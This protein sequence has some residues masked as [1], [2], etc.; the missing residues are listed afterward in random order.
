MKQQSSIPLLVKQFGVFSVVLLFMMTLVSQVFAEG[1]WVGNW[2]VLADEDSLT[3]CPTDLAVDSN[4]TVYV[5]DCGFALVL[6]R[7]KEATGWTFLPNQPY[8]GSN[9]YLAGLAVD[10]ANNVYVLNGYSGTNNVLWKFNGTSWTDITYG[11]MF[12]SPEDIAVDQLNNVYVV[13][14]VAPGDP[15]ANQIRKLS[16]GG[17]TWSVVGNW[18]NGGFTHIASIATDINNN[19]YAIEALSM[20]ETPLGRLVRLP[21]GSSTWLPYPGLDNTLQ[22]LKI[23]NDMAVDRFGNVYVS[24]HLTQ[25]LHVF[26]KNASQWAQIRRDGDVAFNDIF[27]VAVDSKG[28]VYVSDPAVEIGSPNRRILRHQ[29]W[30]TQLTWQT[31]PGGANAYQTLNPSPVLS[32]AGP[33]GD[34]ITGVSSGTADVVL[35][36]PNGATLGGTTWLTLNEGKANFNTLSVDKTGTYT[37]TGHANVVSTNIKHAV[38]AFE[39]VDLSRVSN[40]FTIL[41]APQANAPTANPPSGSTVVDG[42][43]ITLSS[44]TPG[45]IFH[46]TT[47]GS[48]PTSSS[49]IGNVITLSGANGNNVVVK[50]YAS[51]PQYSDSNVVSFNYT[52][53]YVTR[54][55]LIL[56]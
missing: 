37:L 21:S 31:Q 8:N 3:I 6:K 7:E 33:D 1:A 17:S 14:R 45:A 55:P 39:V 34:L 13:D 56:R 43:T 9:P 12:I 29:P 11:T 40:S 44:T 19:L 35:T 28:Y 32:L 10:A 20:S 36:V 47:D 50:A 18:N 26:A 49:P 5:V 48:T 24:D 41:P 2:D 46:Y 23:P 25:D 27:S 4:Q 15:E 54:L 30:A 52:I 53:Q 38:Y 51:A 42:S 16:S 22:M